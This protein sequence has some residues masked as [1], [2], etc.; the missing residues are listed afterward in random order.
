MVGKT[1]ET[2]EIESV[3]MPEFTQTSTSPA[4]TTVGKAPSFEQPLDR[5]PYY[6]TSR[7]AA[8][9]G[10]S[11]GLLENLKRQIESPDEKLDLVIT[12]PP[13]ALQREKEYGNESTGEY[14]AWFRQFA[15]RVYDVLAENGSFVIDIGGGWEEGQPVRSLYHFELLTEL[16]GSDGPFQLAQD[17]YWYNPAKLPTPAQWVTIERIRVTDAVNHVWW[18]SKSDKPKADNRRVLEDYSDAMVRLVEDG[19]ERQER[20]SGHNLSG[21]FDEPSENGSI[22]SNLLEFANT[23][24]NTHYLRA[25]RKCDIEPHPARFPRQLPAFF[26]QFLT[27]PGDLVL[28]IFAGSNTTGRI[29]QDLQRNWLAFEA[30]EKYLQSSQLRFVTIDDI[31]SGTPWEERMDTVRETGD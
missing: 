28:D 31:E 20:P 3:E 14:N 29:A 13:F 26:I 6:T 25:C 12:S 19:S 4:R 15:D 18:L 10:D 17:F 24:S 8:Y 27:E 7:G 30:E 1:P 5:D 21:Q 23:A 16:A 2:P 22:P 9:L 11:I